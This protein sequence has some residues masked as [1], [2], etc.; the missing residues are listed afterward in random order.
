MAFH[1]KILILS[2]KIAMTKTLIIN[3]VIKTR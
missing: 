3:K 1:A 2:I